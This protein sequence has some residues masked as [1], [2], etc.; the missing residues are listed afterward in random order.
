M[1]LDLC[2]GVKELECEFT[3]SVCQERATSVYIKDLY[4]QLLR[5]IDHWHIHLTV[6]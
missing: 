2:P 1:L 4:Y 3:A 5:E 6:G